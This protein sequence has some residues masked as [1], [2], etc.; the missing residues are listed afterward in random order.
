MWLQALRY[1]STLRHWHILVILNVDVVVVDWLALLVGWSDYL[2]S[3][4][5]H[6]PNRFLSL[7]NALLCI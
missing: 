1:V 2:A 5:Y 7:F 4:L 3:S 6:V